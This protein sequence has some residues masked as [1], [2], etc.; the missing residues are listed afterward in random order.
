MTSRSDAPTRGEAVLVLGGRG[1]VGSHVTRRLV[2]AGYRPHLFGPPM[3]DDLLADLAGRFDESHGSVEDRAAVA[4]ALARSGA[5]R[6]V[7]TVAHSVGR[8]GLMRSGDAESDRALAI[9]VLGFRNVLEAALEA[10]V[11]RVV[12]TSSTVVYGSAWDYPGEP[13]DEAAPCRPL[14]FYGLTKQL[15]ED[16]AGYYRNR[17]GLDVVGLRL[18][19][20]LGPGLWYQGAA[21]AITG[22]VAA[23]AAGRAHAFAFHDDPIDLMHVGDVAAAVLA[24]LERG[25]Q[26]E[27]VYNINGFTARMSDILEALARRFGA[28]HVT[29][30]SEEA[31]LRFP[32]IDDRRFRRDFAFAPA[33]DLDGVIQ[34]MLDEETT[35][36]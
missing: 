22:A 25:G 28:L 31:A 26:A 7:T 29:W 9:N 5:R 15:S 19:L 4:E 11:K 14:T 16:L 23:A 10:G 3:A 12:W 17:F 27:A 34:S 13:V 6:L 30:R 8:S 35:D 1:F 32:L 20:V 33:F 24:A 21:A 2:A 36:V 18:P